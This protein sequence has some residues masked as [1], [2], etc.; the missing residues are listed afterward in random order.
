MQAVRVVLSH[1]RKEKRLKCVIL[2]LYRQEGFILAKSKGN[3]GNLKPV[4]TKEEARERGRNGG[5]KS[6]QVQ[7]ERRKARECMEMI[8][9]LD[10]KGKKQKELMSNLGIMDE[11]QI[12]IMSLMASMFMRGVTTGDPTTIKSILEIA[13][14][15]D[16]NL[17]EQTPTININVSAAT[18]DDIEID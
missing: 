2:K 3:I 15:L 4:K 9:S 8:L 7:R 12:N 6:Q 11:E 16:M 13:G 14:D 5:L 17:G 10:V 1:Y 18:P